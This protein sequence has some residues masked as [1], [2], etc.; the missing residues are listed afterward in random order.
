MPVAGGSF[1]LN[2]LSKT[3]RMLPNYHQN[4]KRV[5][6]PC[7][8]SKHGG[9]GGPCPFISAASFVSHQC[10]HR[11]HESQVRFAGRPVQIVGISKPNHMV[12]RMQPPTF[13]SEM[14][15]SPGVGRTPGPFLALGFAYGFARRFET[16]RQLTEAG[17]D[18]LAPLWGIRFAFSA[19]VRWSRRNTMRCEISNWS[20][21]GGI[22]RRWACSVGVFSRERRWRERYEKRR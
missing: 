21:R 16:S 18:W 10:L 9:R 15:L 22:G 11:R 2:Y 17:A 6:Q 14:P 1:K 5:R 13:V 4:R 7:G 3:R 20:A 8:H 12:F 19:S